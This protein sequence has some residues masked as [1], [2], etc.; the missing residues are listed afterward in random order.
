MS[1]GTTD[2]ENW[3]Q[4]NA[5]A[6]WVGGLVTYVAVYAI[7]Y[8]LLKIGTFSIDL[9]TAPPISEPKQALE[10]R[11]RMLWGLSSIALVLIAVAT[12]GWFVLVMLRH[13]AQRNDLLLLIVIITIIIVIIV[14]YLADYGGS[15][16]ATIILHYEG[17]S[18]LP[19][20]S[21]VEFLNAF[22]FSAV[23]LM[24]FGLSSI[25]RDIHNTSV[26]DLV[27]KHH[28]FKVGLAFSSALLVSSV[29]ETY[30]L[31]RMSTINFESSYASSLYTTL[32]LGGSVSYAI[33]LSMLFA[34]IG[35]TLY[36]RSWQLA[37]IAK[38]GND[39]VNMRVWLQ[40]HGV[41]APMRKLVIEFLVAA[42]P[43]IL[44]ALLG[45]TESLK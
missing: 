8:V 32:T 2:I 1:A 10:L 5:L 35:I 14:N 20:N 16:S 23:V 19:L 33:L 18:G 45:A 15:A 3:P 42:L 40:E 41:G 26:E 7:A 34:P 24:A 31:F 25:V 43:A 4:R 11:W 36:S 13:P 22:V 29:L 21:V 27:K 38:S 30:L 39:V 37:R 9:G 12:G 28:S 17:K 6:L 44:G